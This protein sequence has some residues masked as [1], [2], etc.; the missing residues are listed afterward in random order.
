MI[1]ALTCS[2]SRAQASL[3]PPG[4]PAPTLR[5]LD[6]VV[7]SSASGQIV[8]RNIS[9]TAAAQ[10]KVYDGTTTTEVVL[11]SSGLIA[12]DRVAFSG[13]GDFADKN[14]G[15]G[16]A[17]TVSGITA[18]GSDA[19]NYVLSTTSASATADITPRAVTITG[20]TADNKVYDGTVTTTISGSGTI[21]NLVAGDSVT[22]DTS[23]AS[24]AF[25]DKHVGT[26]K[27][28]TISG[29]VSLTGADASNYTLTGATATTSASITPATLV[30]S[31]TQDEKTYDGTVASVARPTTEGLIAGDSVSG[32]VQIFD[33]SDAGNRGLHISAYSIDDGNDG[34]NYRVVKNAAYGYINKADLI[35]EL[36]DV[37]ITAG[38]NPQLSY[39]TGGLK[40]NDVLTGVPSVTGN[41]R[42]AGTYQIS[43]G[44]LSADS[45]YNMHVQPGTLTV[46]PD[47]AKSDATAVTPIVD[48]AYREV[49]LISSVN[50]SEPVVQTVVT[51]EPPEPSYEA[52]KDVGGMSTEVTSP[53][54]SLQP[55]AMCR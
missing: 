49:I 54:I 7:T 47:P 35:V 26:N 37:T 3:T 42:I 17:V 8:P 48:Q 4:A 12:G 44:S 18:T 32:L 38:E 28:V 34:L 51:A 52:D 9:V 19:G 27:T 6:Q 53:Q 36:D 23:A 21:S 50:A 31:A 29:G 14:V 13:N 55:I 22:I 33:N 43:A 40:E 5:T 2:D 11:S 15:T 30:I 46:L 16:K 25:A 20:L 24:G 41:H 45:N 39:S 1:L 10:D